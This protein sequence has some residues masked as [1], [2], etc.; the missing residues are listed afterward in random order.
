MATKQK[1]TQETETAKCTDAHCPIHGGLKTRGRT[2]TGTVIE[3]KAQKT[4]TVEWDRRY[5]LPK[6]ERYEKRITRIKAHNPECLTAKKGEIVTIVEC[7]PLSK[8]KHFVITEKTGKNLAFMEREELLEESKFKTKQTPKQ[9][10]EET[11]E[12]K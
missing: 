11:E 12:Q 10:P 5:Y 3:T 6:Y 9:T 8:T 1:T 7:R 4:A 2:F